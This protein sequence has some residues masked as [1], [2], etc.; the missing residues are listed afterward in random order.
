MAFLALVPAVSLGGFL[1]W[2]VNGASLSASVLAGSG[3]RTQFLTRISLFLGP[4]NLIIGWVALTF[5]FLWSQSLSCSRAFKAF[6]AILSLAKIELY[7][8]NF[9]F[10]FL[11]SWIICFSIKL[12]TEQE[13]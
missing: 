13:I 7:I 3:W 6:N 1:L 2:L 11:S 4:G 5:S 9:L 10:I 8:Y 12:N